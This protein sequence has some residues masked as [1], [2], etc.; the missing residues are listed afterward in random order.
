MPVVVSAEL[1]ILLVE[2]SEFDCTVELWLVLVYE[3]LVAVETL[4]VLV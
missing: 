3:S 1:S 2:P 4:E